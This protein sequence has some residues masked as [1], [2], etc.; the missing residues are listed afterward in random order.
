MNLIFSHHNLTQNLECFNS[1]ANKQFFFSLM[2]KNF[3]EI[4]LRCY[5]LFLLDLNFLQANTTEDIFNWLDTFFVPAMWPKYSL[6]SSVKI[7]YDQRFM[8]DDYSYRVSLTQM[9]Q[10]RRMG[11]K[12]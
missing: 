4:N 9:R 11:M 5:V 8:I 12:S 2:I 1:N 3:I 10:V 7:N 6:N